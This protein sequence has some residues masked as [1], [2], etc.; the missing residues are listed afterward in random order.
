MAIVTEDGYVARRSPVPLSKNTRVRYQGYT[1]WWTCKWVSEGA[2]GFILPK[3]KLVVPQEFEGKRVRLKIEVMEEGGVSS[4][5][6]KRVR[7]RQS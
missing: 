3:G 7:K 6:R 2:V 4:Y 1:D 5:W